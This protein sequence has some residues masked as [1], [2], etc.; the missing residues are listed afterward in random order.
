MSKPR[1]PLPQAGVPAAGAS[2]SP[3]G[4]EEAREPVLDVV[5][6]VS[7][8][9]FGLFMALTF[10]GAVSSAELGPDASRTMLHAALGCNLA[11]GLVDAVMYLVRTLASRG[12]RLTLAHA[13]RNAADGSARA[14]LV[15]DALPRSMKALV[16]EAELEAMHTRLASARPLPERSRLHWADFRAAAYVFGIVVL[17]TFPVVLPFVI[18]SDV[19]TALFV[20]RSLTLAMLFVGG[21]ALGHYAGFG[22]VATGLGMTALGV[23]LTMAIIALGG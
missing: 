7:E 21:T 23:V 18:W 20:S 3:S 1:N 16:A 22:G 11:W 14:R 17:S 9:C 10:V 19:A 2:A 5:D 13:L 15:R 4:G 12:Q 6:R 8:M